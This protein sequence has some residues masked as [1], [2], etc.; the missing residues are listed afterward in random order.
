[1]VDL[2]AVLLDVDDTLFDRNLAQRE[3][4]R[5]IVRA[6]PALFAGVDEEAAADAFLESDRL[7]VE[8]LEAGTLV[9]GYR[10][11]RSKVF[12]DLLGLGEEWAGQITAWYVKYYPRIDAPVQGARFL[13]RSLAR[14]FQLGIVSNGLADVQYQK[15]KTLGFWH[16]FGCVVISEDV[17]LAKPDPRIF[18]R[19]AELLG[20]QPREC[21]HIG[22][23]YEKDVVGARRAG[24]RVC[25]FNPSGL[26]P[27]QADSEPDFEVR[28]LGGIPGI[29]NDRGRVG[30]E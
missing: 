9:E 1:M 3:A 30:N 22:D 28:A 2:K 24:M 27:V 21:L 14:R 20:R 4:I 18:W 13:T 6:F 12:L 15:L 7:T 26:R 5:L 19:A 29:L 25:W 10:A 17:G 8:E 23:S 11:R 16:L